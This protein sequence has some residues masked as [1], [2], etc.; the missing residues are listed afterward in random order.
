MVLREVVALRRMQLRDSDAPRDQAQQPP[1]PADVVP[2]GQ[3]RTSDDANMPL[4][5]SKRPHV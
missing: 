1:P 4:S 5:P 3:K 2:R